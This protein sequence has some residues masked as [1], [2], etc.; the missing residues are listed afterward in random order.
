MDLCIRYSTV[1]KNGEKHDETSDDAEF[2]GGVLNK[3]QPPHGSKGHAHA[4][5]NRNEGQKLV[6][7]F[8]IPGVGCFPAVLVP[9]SF[10]QGKEKTSCL[11][12]GPFQEG[13]G[14]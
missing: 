14:R 5:K 8:A 7:R 1:H 9:F 10:D 6:H 12:K 13:A 3:L 11:G 4:H 2:L